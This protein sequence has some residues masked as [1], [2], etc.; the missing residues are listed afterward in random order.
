M[1]ERAMED[2]GEGMAQVWRANLGVLTQGA[3]A[4]SRLARMMSLSASLLTLIRTGQRE[5]SE[6]FVRGVEA[7]TGLPPGW[8]D[9]PRRTDDIPERVRTAL[10]TET[11]FAKFRGTVHAARKRTVLKSGCDILGRSDAARR[12]VAVASGEAGRNRRRAHFR[13]VR[14][15]AAQEARRL[16][17]HFN[18]PPAALAVLRAKVKDVM[19][20]EV[21]FDACVRA[22]LAGRMEQIEKHHDLLKRHIEKL[23]ALLT[24]LDQA[25]RT[26]EDR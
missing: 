2:S 8:M 16:E 4:V 3:G 22:D 11:P 1:D 18:H 14:D 21:E 12:A 13:K 19:D 20:A 9:T 6:A 7:V 24:R 25:E 23:Y 17:W 5:F 26:A 10:D 15:L